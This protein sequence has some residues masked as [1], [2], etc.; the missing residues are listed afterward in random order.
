MALG[1]RLLADSLRQGISKAR[2]ERARCNDPGRQRELDEQIWAAER[3]VV[4]LEDEAKPL[5]A[6]RPRRRKG[7]SGHDVPW[8]FT[9]C[10]RGA[11]L[12]ANG[13]E[14]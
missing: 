5:R 10:P 9:A 11:S 8:L 3:E 12:G 13:G 7:T 2:E 14:T 1:A 6:R 4:R